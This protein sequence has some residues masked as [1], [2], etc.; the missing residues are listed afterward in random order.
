MDRTPQIVAAIRKEQAN[1]A[2][3]AEALRWA[4][5]LSW[6]EFGDDFLK[7]QEPTTMSSTEF[8]DA[9]ETI[10]IKRGTAMNR[11]SEARRN[12]IG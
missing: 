5:W 4:V 8:A 2:T 12:W 6:E 10:G 3:Q 9:A 11:F 1:S 7:G